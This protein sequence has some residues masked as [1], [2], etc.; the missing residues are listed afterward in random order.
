MIMAT[1]INR[2]LGK[3]N[4]LLWNIPEDLKYFKEQTE[5][6]NVVM[7]MNTFKSLPFKN[8]LP[9]RTNWVITND[10][11]KYWESTDNVNFLSL[12]SIAYM[13]NTIDKHEHFWIIGGASIYDQ[14]IYYVDEIHW[15]L[16]NKEFREADTYLTSRVFNEIE[17]NFK[18]T[19]L[20]KSF[21]NDDS[22]LQATVEIL[23]RI[24]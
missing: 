21:K 23:K 7:G 15:T 18:Y 9:N 12:N 17:N 11:V 14:L 1:G 6:F 22:D 20:G 10:E 16:V 5:Y 2:E 3:D 19:T 13:L 24:K 8:G 4:K